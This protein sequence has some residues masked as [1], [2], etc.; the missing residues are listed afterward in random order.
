[1][2]PE[3]ILGLSMSYQL[4]EQLGIRAQANN[5]TNEELRIYRDNNPHRLG[6]F[7]EY[8]PNYLVDFTYSF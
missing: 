2:L 3:S 5:L 7:D 8:G 4:T 6:R 1:L